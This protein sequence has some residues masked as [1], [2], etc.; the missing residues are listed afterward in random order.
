[1]AKQSITLKVAG[2]GYA[3][4]VDS[5]KEEIYRLAEREVNAYLSRL[6]QQK[7]ENW[8]EKDYL[9][10]TALKFAIANVDMRQSREV[11]SEELKQLNALAT[12]IDQYL[13]TLKK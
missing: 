12:Q 13:N 9:A 4:E 11:G 1:M 10:M 3:L 8:T 6:M 7:Y 5:Q 2:R